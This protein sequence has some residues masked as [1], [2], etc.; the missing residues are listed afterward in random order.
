M[1]WVKTRYK[2]TFSFFFNN[3]AIQNYFQSKG[4]K[5]ES[6]HMNFLKN[7]EKKLFVYSS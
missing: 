5:N 3:F 4:N 6:S 1:C 2:R 7:D